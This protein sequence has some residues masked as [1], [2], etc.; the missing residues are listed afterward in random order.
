MDEG[1]V[2]IPLSVYNGLLGTVAQV[3]VIERMLNDGIYVSET[4]LR[5]ILNIEKREVK[6]A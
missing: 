5:A 2:I 6:D 4:D 3:A 1:R